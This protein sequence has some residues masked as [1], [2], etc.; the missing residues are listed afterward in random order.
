[1]SSVMWQM[2]IAARGHKRKEARL[3]EVP[4]DGGEL[5]IGEMGA[6]LLVAG[7]SVHRAT[8]AIRAGDCDCAAVGAG[9]NAFVASASPRRTSLTLCWR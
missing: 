4:G 1:M 9:A 6:E 7:M 2:Y 8:F 5:Q 3:L